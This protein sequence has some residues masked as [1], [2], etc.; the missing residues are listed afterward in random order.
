[1]NGNFSGILSG[2]AISLLIVH[3]WIVKVAAINPSSAKRFR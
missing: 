2:A 1:M 3:L